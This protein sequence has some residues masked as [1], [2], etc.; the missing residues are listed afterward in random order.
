MPACG[1]PGGPPETDNPVNPADPVKE[2]SPAAV[3]ALVARLAATARA[4]GFGADTFGEIA[5]VPLLALTRPAPAARPRVYLSAGIHGDEPAPPQ[6]LLELLAGGFFDDACSWFVC[7]VLNPGGLARG[8]RENPEG[9]DLNRD[10]RSRVAAEVRAHVAWLRRQPAFEL[11]LC[12]HEDWEARG[13][14]LYEL[15]PDRRPSLAEP[16]VAA[17]QA[18]GPID[19]AEIIDGRPAR[20]GVIRPDGDP[21]KRDQW[22]EAIYLRAHHTRL[23][24][25]LETA[26]GR[27]LAERVAAHRAAVE[28]ARAGL[29]QSLPPAPI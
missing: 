11:T 8:T 5:G 13:F 25:T 27:P 7:P 10:Y 23:S 4:A 2:S 21:A 16:I 3:A 15:N 1:G 17:V 22:P 9:R 24:Y 6:A 14:Y 26:S 20:G 12:L 29:L 28:A 19:E 18:I